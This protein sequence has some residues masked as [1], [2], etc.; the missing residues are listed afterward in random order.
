MWIT[1]VAHLAEHCVA[2]CSTAARMLGFITPREPAAAGSCSLVCWVGRSTG[3]LHVR[4]AELADRD[5]EI[6]ARAANPVPVFKGRIPT[7]GPE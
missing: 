7:V 2:E 5:L 4:E 3:R 1:T 6:E